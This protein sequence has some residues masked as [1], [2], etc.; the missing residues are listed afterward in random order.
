MSPTTLPPV[1]PG[2]PGEPPAPPAPPGA[3]PKI[4]AVVV[5]DSAYNRRVIT[6]ILESSGEVEVVG[7]ASD[8]EAGL[9]QVLSL[10]PDIICLDLEMPRMDGFTFLRIL[11]SRQP[12]PVIVVSSQAQKANVFKAL[13]FGALD[14]VAKPSPAI[15]SEL[16]KIRDELLSKVALVRSLKMAP[17][18]ERAA[19]RS[20]RGDSIPMPVLRAPAVPG[21]PP[22]Q[23]GSGAVVVGGVAGGAAPVQGGS[24]AFA[25]VAPA[26]EGPAP[27]PEELV[28]LAIGAST[29]GPPAIQQILQGIEIGFAGAIL[30]TQHMPERFTRAFAQRLDRLLGHAVYEAEDGMVVRQ[31]GV[32]VS[33]GDASM[34]VHREGAAAVL[35]LSRAERRYVPSIDYMLN[36]A[37]L[38]FGRRLMAAILTGMG[39]D[40]TEGVAA[41]RRAGGRVVAESRETAVVYGMPGAAVESGQVE[42]ILPLGRLV[43]TARTFL[44][45]R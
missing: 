13:E 19:A 42:Q 33:P 44:H 11:M 28:L 35:R 6:G 10:R 43:E 27:T 31:G 15:S 25:V 45:R 36:T 26:P 23:S 5:E 39:T 1:P 7:K 22:S 20:L 24:G 2:P 14:F 29:G 8:G 21:A 38:L 16:L 17:L 12:T 18:K 3:A 37:A 32:Y 34:G 9:Q 4:R 40:G 41:V 30:V